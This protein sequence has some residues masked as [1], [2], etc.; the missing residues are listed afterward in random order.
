MS[1]IA[2]TLT[3]AGNDAFDFTSALHTYIEVQDIAL[4]KVEGLK[5][6]NYLDKVMDHLEKCL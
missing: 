6:L 3:Y 1:C 2:K 5:G 4:A